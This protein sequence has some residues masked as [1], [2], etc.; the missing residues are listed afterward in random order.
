LVNLED[1]RLTVGSWRDESWS[2]IYSAHAEINSPDELLERVR[3]EILMSSTSL[4]PGQPV[5]IFVHAPA[6][7]HLPF[8]A[9]QGVRFTRL[10]TAQKEAGSKYAFALMGIAA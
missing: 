9:L 5:E 2:W 8:G 10:M 1:G 4:K 6:F 3:K 7:E